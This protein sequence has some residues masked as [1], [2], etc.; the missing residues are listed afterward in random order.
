MMKERNEFARRPIFCAFGAGKLFGYVG[1][2]CIHYYLHH[3][4][5][6]PTTHLHFQKVYHHNHHFKEYDVGEWASFIF[7]STS[8]L[9]LV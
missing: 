9:K 5:P 4:A 8:L 3:G 2:D 1:Y 6:R 7:S